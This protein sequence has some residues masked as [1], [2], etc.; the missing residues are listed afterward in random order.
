[1]PYGEFGAGRVKEGFD[2][3]VMTFSLI[4]NFKSYFLFVLGGTLFILVCTTTGQLK[5]RRIR[6]INKHTPGSCP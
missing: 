6:H 1:M 2:S 3:I 5:E 4:F